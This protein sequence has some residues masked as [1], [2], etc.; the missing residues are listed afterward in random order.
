MSKTSSLNGKAF[1][2]ACLKAFQ[3]RLNQFQKRNKLIEDKPYDTAKKNFNSLQSEEQ[4]KY[5]MAAATAAKA[6]FPLEPQ[7]RYGKG[8]LE[9]SINIDRAAQ[10]IDGDVRDVMIIRHLDSNERWE[11]GLSC[12]HNHEALKH[13]RITE[14]DDF[15]SN[16]IGVPCSSDFQDQ[17][18]KV[19]QKITTYQKKGALWRDIDN[20]QDK[21]YLPIIEAYRNEIL[22]M[23]EDDA[24]TAEKLLSYFFGSK[25][26]YKVIMLEK[27]NVVKI[28]AFNMHSSLGKK[29]GEMEPSVTIEKLT[30]PTKLIDTKLKGKTTLLLQFD[31]EWSISMRLHNKDKEVKT[32]SLAWDVSLTNFPKSIYTDEL[33][34]DK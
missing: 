1:E 8:L 34:W 25:D 2:Y 20:K 13:P 29:A 19:L 3:N 18:K 28:E 24:K 15:G 5:S 26:F 30:M 17:M 23:C 21:F 11:I 14:Q 12:K 22:R 9:L 16:W 6:I 32:T 4:T 33:S 27:E 10:G 7:L 31:E